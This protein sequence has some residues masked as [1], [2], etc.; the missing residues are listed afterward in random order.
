M[1]VGLTIAF[2]MAAAGFWPIPVLGQAL[3]VAGGLSALGAVL[4]IPGFIKSRR[5]SR[6]DLS[7]LRQIHEREELRAIDLDEPMEY[8]SV[9]CLNCGEV[10]TARQAICPRCGAAQGRR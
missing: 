9:H 8:D 5:D 4:A 1:Y 10:Y 6:Y 7:D 2:T 3:A